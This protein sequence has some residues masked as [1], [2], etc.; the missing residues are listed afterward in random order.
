MGDILVLHEFC[1]ELESYGCKNQLLSAKYGSKVGHMTKTYP[2]KVG[3]QVMVYEI[4][5]MKP[6]II[7]ETYSSK[8]RKWWYHVLQ[9][10]WKPI[11]GL[12]T[13]ITK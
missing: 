4:Q 5:Y 2:V 1:L 8:Q 7:K 12:D 10:W 13:V 11:E 9:V 3:H 6:K